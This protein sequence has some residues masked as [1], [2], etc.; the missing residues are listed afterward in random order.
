MYRILGR[1]KYRSVKPLL[2]QSV[3]KRFEDA[4]LA[5]NSP[6][7]RKLLEHTDCSGIE[8]VD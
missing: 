6:A 8:P 4:A 5:H 1:P 7:L 3:K 2:H